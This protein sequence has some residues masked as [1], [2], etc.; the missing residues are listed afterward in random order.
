MANTVKTSMNVKMIPLVKA[1]IK[2]VKMSG[3]IF[4]VNPQQNAKS[5]KLVIIGKMDAV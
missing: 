2:L 5:V 1:R 4:F 3:A